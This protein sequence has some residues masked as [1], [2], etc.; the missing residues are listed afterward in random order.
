[1]AKTAT[2]PLTFGDAIDRFL[3]DG[4]LYGRL[5]SDNSVQAYA[6]GLQAH[7]EDAGGLGP[8]ETTRD[9]VKSTLARYAYPRTQAHRHTIMVGFYDWLIEEGLRLDNPARQVRRNRKVARPDVYRL[10]KPEAA[11]LMASCST[12]R[13]RRLVYLGLLTGGRV[14]EFAQMCGHHFLRAGYVLISSDIAKGGKERWIPVMPELA[15]VI[16]EIV[17]TTR[18]DEV[19]LRRT[20][21]LSGAQRGLCGEQLPIG[22]VMLTRNVRDV[23]RRA[24]IAGHVTPHTLRHA[25]GDHIAKYAGLRIAQALMGH[26]SVETTASTYTSRVGLEELTGAVAEFRYTGDVSATTKSDADAPGPFPDPDDSHLEIDVLAGSDHVDL[27]A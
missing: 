18:P 3:D 24:G 17:R 1:M 2:A 19:V 12:E 4:R 6:I 10:T 21:V 11:R 16:A 9:H 5:R 14:S 26:V 27:E 23:A 22:R 8:L 13:E 15:P 25:F 7:W 20:R